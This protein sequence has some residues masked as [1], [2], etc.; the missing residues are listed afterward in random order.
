M[1]AEIVTI[2]QE[3]LIG[4]VVDTNS[5]FIG[6]SLR[7]AG[8]NVMRIT[9]V[10]DQRD[11]ILNILNETGKRCELV[12]STGGLGPTSDD[13]TK[14][15]LCD[16]FETKLVFNEAAYANIER[17]F[18]ARKFQINETNRLQAFLPEKATVLDNPSGTAAGLWLEKGNTVYIFLPGVPFEMQGLMVNEVI[19]RIKQRF[20]LPVIFQKTIITQGGY[21][22]LMAEQLKPWEN[23]LNQKGI[24]LAW[25]PSPGIIRLRLTIQGE[26]E[27]TLS[28]TIDQA[29][30][31]LTRYIPENIIGFDEDTLQVIVGRLLK[32]KGLTLSTAESCTGGTIGSMLVSVAGSSEYFKGGAIVY[33]DEAKINIL[34]V[35]PDTIA[36]H[37]AVSEHVVTQM[38]AGANKKFSTDIAVAVSGIAGPGGGTDEKPVGTTWIAV[39]YGDSVIA[40]RFQFGEHRGRNITRTALTALRMVREVIIKL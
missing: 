36:A 28:R 6:E 17:I 1:I 11:E 37:G 38:A 12:I 9:S 33:S 24:A 39:A 23:Y 31:E 32:E 13:I 22:G 27:E 34:G 29:V 2:G 15:V 3:L 16:F 26:E 5:A 7:K 14:E 4:Q 35:N 25:L 18:G 20:K 40:E 8:A 10:S 21:E 19:P 30:E